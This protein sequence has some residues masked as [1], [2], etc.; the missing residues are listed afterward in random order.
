[1]ETSLNLSEA[2]P[3]DSVRSIRNQCVAAGVP[4][5]FKQWG[6]VNQKTDRELDGRFWG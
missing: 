1:V 3:A 2:V 4:L 6:G 5:M